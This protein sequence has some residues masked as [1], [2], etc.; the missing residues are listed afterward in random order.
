MKTPIANLS[1]ANEEETESAPLFESFAQLQEDYHIQSK[2]LAVANKILRCGHLESNLRDVFASIIAICQEAIGAT[3]TTIEIYDHEKNELVGVASD[4]ELYNPEGHFR[5]QLDTPS[6]SGLAFKQRMV[7]AIDDVKNDSRVDQ[8]VRARFDAVSGI[9]APLIFGGKIIGVILSMMQNEIYHF[10]TRDIGIMEGLAYEASMAVSARMQY[11]NSL[12]MEQRYHRLVENAPSAIFLLDQ[13]LV[14]LEANRPAERMLGMDTEA[15]LGMKLIKFVALLERDD[16][17]SFFASLEF[18]RPQKLE[19]SFR[20]LDAEQFAVEI[21][22][23]KLIL[24]GQPHIQVFVVD[25]T[26]RKHAETAL[27]QEKER[28]QTTLRAITNA[29]IT[30]DHG[31][32][33]ASMN[34]AACELTGWEFSEAVERSVF[35]ILRIE[36]NNGGNMHNFSQAIEQGLMHG[37][38][39]ELSS[40]VNLVSR[41]G[42]EHAVEVSVAAIHSH[43]GDNIGAV[44]VIDDV[45]DAL[46]MAEKMSYLAS[47]DPLTG[48]VNRGE[49]ELRLKSALKEAIRYKVEHVLCYIDLDR[50]KVVNDTVGHLAG[51]QLLVQLTALL[52]SSMRGSDTLARLGGDEF[53]VLLSRCKLSDA[54]N[55]AENIRK[56]VRQF[57]FS[58]EGKTFEI[59][60]SI[61][62]VAIDECSGSLQEILSAVDSACYVAKE[63]GRNR[64]QVFKP[65]DENLSKRKSEMELSHRIRQ[66]LEE[67]RI[68]LW[69][70]RI[71][72][73][74]DKRKDEHYV[75][76]FVRMLD[77]DG[78]IA[79]PGI[80]LGAAERYQIMPDI[81]RWVVE[82]A[83]KY[84]RDGM[85]PNGLYDTCFINLSGQSLTDPDFLGFV[86][87]MF[88]Q[89]KI[90]PQQICFELTETAAIHNLAEAMQFFS[91]LRKKGCRFALDDFGSG[92]SSFAYLKN[93]PVDFIKID[94]QFIKDITSNVVDEA[95][96]TAINNIG[97]ALGIEII[98]EYVENDN[99]FK[100]VKNLGLDF[101]QGYFL[102]R[103]QAV[104]PSDRNR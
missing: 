9:A 35:E 60:A 39:T 55:I 41:N 6:L 20:N 27:Y 25:I 86:T 45:S 73:T 22:A 43:S 61:G 87:Q 83:F 52:Q 69:M 3:T 19:T 17:K 48:L 32:R 97:H 93:L 91:H 24:S 16:A 34:P 65:D 67:N 71:F 99:T 92:L 14:I 49:F 5:I 50:F 82:H 11:Q 15:L 30:T 42:K 100:V 75:E 59:G 28:A 31:G 29:V 76:I 102:D 84:V 66:A 88:S 40:G 8:T 53:G 78:N 21:S 58:W 72:S 62:V 10:T 101:V 13:R 44:I 98:G 77:Q 33:V 47:H 68:R 80:F 56:V 37:K 64:V 89:Y 36:S 94:G 85:L 95:M 79:P 70:Q 46:R 12:D 54:V 38:T 18:D 51:D 104:E 4:R 96:V 57:R 7:I 23:N 81:D 74:N 26:L 90:A 1:S 63:Q 103:P 2:I